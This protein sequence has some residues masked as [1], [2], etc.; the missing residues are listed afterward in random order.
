[1][2]LCHHIFQVRSGAITPSLLTANQALSLAHELGDESR[3]ALAHRMLG[4]S[5]AFGGDRVSAVP[6]FER[7][8]S[9]GVPDDANGFLAET[10][11]F[12]ALVCFS[13]TLWLT[14]HPSR[15]VAIAKEAVLTGGA[16]RQP[17]TACTCYA[18]TA[19]IFLWSDDHVTAGQLIEQLMAHATR[20]S[21]S[22][23]RSFAVGLKGQLH[24]ASGEHEL[25]KTLLQDALHS[26]RAERQNTFGAPFRTSLAE[27]LARAGDFAGAL[28]ALNDAIALAD[29]T[30]GRFHL[31][32][33]LRVTGA[34]LLSQPGGDLR[35]ANRV[36]S[37]SIALARQQG[38]PSWELRSA[39]TLAQVKI[40][41]GDLRA[42]KRLLEDSCGRLPGE[43]ETPDLVLARKLL[44][45]LDC[46]DL[47]Q[48]PPEYEG[49]DVGR[50]LPREQRGGRRSI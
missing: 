35:E 38:S 28:A 16:S 11:C 25:A 23:F 21:L 36:L 5:C 49:A 15:A 31:P 47:P 50:T 48:P 20:Y 19:Q 27:A 17:V 41:E 42:A 40:K 8:F 39:I 6:H 4:V 46:R 37:E 44:R 12:G 9:H 32:E 34:V 13:R 33:T 1:M 22:M 7:G 29:E 43:C 10:H 30:G 14:G 3:I 26:L 45:T 24:L 2:L 18:F